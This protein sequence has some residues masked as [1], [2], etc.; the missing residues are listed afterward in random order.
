M[1]RP[2]VDHRGDRLPAVVHEI[3]RRLRGVFGTAAAEVLLWSGSAAWESALVNTLRAGD[4]VL[5]F[6]NGLFAEKFVEVAR[7]FGVVVDEVQKRWGDAVLASDVDAALR[8]DHRAL[9]IVHNETSTGVT[10]DLAGVRAAIDA[11]GHDPLLL[12]DAVSSL[13]SLPFR[14]DEWRVDVALTGSQK[15]LMM[16]PGLAILCVSER[17]LRAATAVDTPRYFHDWG[18]VVAA[19]AQGYSPATP[20]TLEFYGLREA[21][22]MLD[23]EGLDAVYARHARLGE[24]VRRAVAAWDRQLL[25]HDLERCSNSLT[26]VWLDDLD[27]NQLLRI[28]AS[29]LE[30]DLGGGLGRL[31]GRVFRMG[32]L[33]ALNEL[34]VLAMLGGVEMGLALAG[35]PVDLGRGVAAAQAHFVQSPA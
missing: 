4:R 7:R 12:V 26:A 13:G 22:R 35:A 16:P 18:P 20:P 21:L 33:G 23:E 14:F 27:A 15:G 19:L 24:G 28:T 29:R 25:C 11:G 10:T 5:S 1:D 30:L 6:N 2:V 17:A 9:L 8:A 3:R 32:H 34:E 31:N